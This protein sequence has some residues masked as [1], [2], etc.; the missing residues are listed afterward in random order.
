VDTEHKLAAFQDLMNEVSTALADMLD[1]MKDKQSTT[2]EISNTL[3]DLKD[4]IEASQDGKGLQSVVAAIKALKLTAPAPVVQ[5]LEREPGG[6][7]RLSVT[8]DEHDRITSAL[9]T[10]VS[11]PSPNHL[12]PS[13]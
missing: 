1:A 2:D 7:Y 11:K 10:R 6:D 8:Y 12:T 5:L 3:I 13:P 4:A 9:I